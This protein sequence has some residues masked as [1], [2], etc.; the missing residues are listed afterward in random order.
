MA[1]TTAELRWICAL[2]TELGVDLSQQLVVYSDN[3]GATSL[4]A[5][6]VF[7]S[8]MKHVSLGYHF[9]CDQVQN[10][11]LRIAHVS[12]SNQLVYALTKPLPRQ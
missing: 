1:T 5:N 12:S 9:I 8:R 4:W 11:L 2:L 10:G 3:V 6:P 7:H